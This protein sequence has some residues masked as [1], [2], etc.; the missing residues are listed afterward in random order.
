MSKATE[1][2]RVGLRVRKVADKSKG[3]KFDPDTGDPLPWPCAGLAIENDGGHPPHVRVPM[4]WVER[5]VAEKWLTLEGGG[6]PHV[7]PGGEV[8]NPWRHDR[9]HT[10]VRGTAVVLHC[11]DGCDVRYRVVHQ[12]GKYY[13]SDGA[14]VGA[15]LDRY[16]EPSHVDWF[17]DLDLEPAQPAE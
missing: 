15:N 12:P 10:F 13:D 9:L 2:T 14:E 5:G 6:R 16:G 3:R 7:E 4:S 11:A 17:F 8:G 1:T